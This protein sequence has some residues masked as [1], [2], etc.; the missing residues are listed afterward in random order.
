[1]AFQYYASLVLTSSIETQSIVHS[2]LN[3]KDEIRMTFS[4]NHCCVSWDCHNIIWFFEHMYLTYDYL[5]LRVEA[6]Q[7]KMSIFL[8]TWEFPGLNFVWKKN[9]NSKLFTK[10]L[11]SNDHIFVPKQLKYLRNLYKIGWK[12]LD[13]YFVKK[14]QS[15]NCQQKT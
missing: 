3:H 5:L 1:M 15:S 12:I 6:S 10:I 14:H 13:S 4:I 8:L 2:Q 11:K 9:E 7:K